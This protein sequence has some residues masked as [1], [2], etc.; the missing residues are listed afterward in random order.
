VGVSIVDWGEDAGLS[1][2][3]CRT[4]DGGQVRAGYGIGG[5]VHAIMQAAGFGLGLSLSDR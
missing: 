2:E 4:M 1:L 5:P 3:Q